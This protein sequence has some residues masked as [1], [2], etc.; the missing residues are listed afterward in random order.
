[1]FMKS[2]TLLDLRSSV[3]IVKNE[4]VYETKSL[5]RDLGETAM[6]ISFWTQQ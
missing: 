2:N 5:I 6:A 3:V 1:L 4:V